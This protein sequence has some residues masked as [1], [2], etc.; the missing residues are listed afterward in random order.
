LRTLEEDSESLIGSGEMSPPLVDFNSSAALNA[1]INSVSVGVNNSGDLTRYLIPNHSNPNR[2]RASTINILDEPMM[3]RGLGVP[4]SGNGGMAGMGGSSRFRSGTVGVGVGIGRESLGVGVG[5]GNGGYGM[6]D[7]VPKVLITGT[8][9][10]V[11]G[12]VRLGGDEEVSCCFSTRVFFS[13][14]GKLQSPNYLPTPSHSPSPSPNPPPTQLPS[15]SL[16]IGN[17]SPSIT[18]QDLMTIF[19]PYGAIES[20]RLLPEKECGFVN[21]VSLN[22][23]VKAKDDV[24]NRLGGKIGGSGNGK[25]MNGNSNGNGNGKNSGN[26]GGIVRIGFGKIDNLPSS[27][28]FGNLGTNKSNLVNPNGSITNPLDSTLQTSPTRAL[29]VGSIPP[30]TTPSELLKIF[31]PYGP[32]ESARVLTHKNCGFI[33]FERLDDAV[34]ARR[35]LNGREILGTEV[36]QVRIGFAKVPGKGE[37]GGIVGVG[38]GTPGGFGVENFKSNLIWGLMVN[39]GLEDGYTSGT[40]T[41][42]GGTSP[43]GVSKGLKKERKGFGI[44]IGN[45]SEEEIKTLKVEINDMQLLMRELS[46]G[47]QGEE[48]D[49][50]RV[51]DS[52]PPVTYYTSIPPAQTEDPNSGKKF[53]MSD[54]ARLRE[55]RKKLDGNNVS[56]EEIDVIATDLLEDS[57]VLASDYIGNTLIQKF[58]ERCSLNVKLNLLERIGPHLAS[59][60]CHKNGTWAAQKII[61]S[62]TSEEEI[63]MICENVRPY[64][65]PLL[66]DQ[67]GNYVVQCTLKFGSPKADIIFDSM[68]DRCWEIGQGRFGARSMRTCLDS[69]NATRFQKVGLRFPKRC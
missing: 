67:F 24:L 19:A 16:W 21:F 55:I 62:A 17:L 22:D 46:S 54:A 58:F 33:N 43:S 53:S 69:E 37:E 35:S 27:S 40:G 25:G 51:K 30:H 36:G 4:A 13:D 52:R 49:E 8:L 26:G 14:D 28:S 41:R 42:S 7:E 12:N 11:E 23:A 68:I 48:Q 39:G 31:S 44:G 50:E 9:D 18:A 10:G 1:L 59:I 38:N 56:R 32:I 34:T 20:L 2:A 6:G 5:S 57:V 45:G 47:E 15:R 64:L 65:P 66:L 61:D 60:G 3:V 29:W 63:K